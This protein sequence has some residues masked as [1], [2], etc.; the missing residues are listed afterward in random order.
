MLSIAFHVIT[1]QSYI[2]ETGHILRECTGEHL[3][4]I[5]RNP[6]SFPVAEHF[7]KPGHR[8]DNMEVRLVKQCRGTNNARC[9]DEMRLIFHLGT[10]WLRGLKVDFNSLTCKHFYPCIRVTQFIQRPVPFKTQHST[11]EG[12]GPKRLL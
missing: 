2:G 10:L 8:L 11:E 7:N 4:A 9:R 12:L 1:A 3:R 5:M 6:P